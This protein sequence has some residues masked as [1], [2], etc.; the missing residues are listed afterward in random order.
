MV[1]Y[2]HDHKPWEEMIGETRIVNPGN[3][4]NIFYAPT[5]AIFDTETGKLELKILSKI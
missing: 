3:L 1:F 5:F 2:G 4:A